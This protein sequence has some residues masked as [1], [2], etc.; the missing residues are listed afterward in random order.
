[1]I[2]F[3]IALVVFGLCVAP[4]LADQTYSIVV[5]D[6][7]DAGVTWAREQ[8]NA[9]C[10]CAAVSTNTA[11]MQ[12]SS[13][14]TADGYAAQRQHTVVDS[15]LTTCRDD[16]PGCAAAVAAAAAAFPH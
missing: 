7:Q 13:R 11:F 9:T 8:Y 2:R 3:P 4:A 15:V 12:L 16:P 6:D 10:K 1:M 5:T 14:I